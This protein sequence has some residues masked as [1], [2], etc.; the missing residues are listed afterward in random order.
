MVDDGQFWRML[1]NFLYFGNFGLDYLFHMFFLVRYCRAL[2]EGEFANI[3]IRSDLDNRCAELLPADTDGVLLI[4]SS[5]YRSDLDRV[6][7]WLGRR[8]LT[9]SAVLS[10]TL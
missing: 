8:G 10:A 9:A 6:V 3:R 7:V 1:T 4:G 5:P 2:E